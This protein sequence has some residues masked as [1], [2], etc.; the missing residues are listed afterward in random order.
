MTDQVELTP[1][2]PPDP[3]LIQELFDQDPLKLSD[4]DIDSMIA[5]FRAERINYLRPAEEKPKKAPKA[6]ATKI[7]AE[8]AAAAA[9]LLSDLGL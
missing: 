1:I 7:S 8:Q 9:D 2:S 6:K 4:T 3:H 5:Y